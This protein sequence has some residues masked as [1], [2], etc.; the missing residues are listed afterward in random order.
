MTRT[1]VSRKRRVTNHCEMHTKLTCAPLTLTRTR[2]PPRARTVG[3]SLFRRQQL[4]RLRLCL[5]QRI[6]ENRRFCGE[7]SAHLCSQDD[8]SGATHIP[9]ELWARSRFPAPCVLQCDPHCG[10][11]PS[12]WLFHHGAVKRPVLCKSPT[13]IR[14]TK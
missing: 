8:Q 13:A 5:G 10:L 9:C 4:S 7:P 1:R 12:V 3:P 14:S 2:A 11:L 6:Q